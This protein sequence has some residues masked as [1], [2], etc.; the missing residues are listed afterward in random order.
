[1]TLALA[2]QGQVA[3]RGQ[4]R[5][6]KRDAARRT[7]DVA[8]LVEPGPRILVERIDI[9]GNKKTKDF[10]IR[11]EFQVAEGAP[12]N[13]FMI[14]RGRKRVQALGFFKSVAVQNRT[15]S[16]PD[17]AVITITV[18][19][20]ESN[21]LSFGVGYS[22]QEG[23]IGDISLT[24]R[25]FLGN[26]QWLRLKLEGSLTRLQ[27]EVGFTEPRFLG[28]NLAA[29]FDL[30]YKDV[31]YTTQA[32]YMSQKIGGTPARRAIPSTR[33]GR[34]ASTTRSCATSST[35]LAPTRRLPS[36]RPFP[37][38]RTRPPRPTTPPR[39][40]TRSPTIRATTRS[41]RPPAST[42]PS[43]RISPASAATCG[44]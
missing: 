3:V 13:A 14:E 21:D 8:F 44:S 41:G 6:P 24:E 18:V 35:M 15:G 16:A 31:D 30:F 2:D 34:P 22:M 19:E 10:V 20:Q 7:I 25:N 37:A 39:S 1:M 5:C 12:V 9:V 32:S 28:T 33:S 4:G 38:S 27:A 23:V 36:R 26:G 40:A 42:T 29:G 17:Q 11:R 43:P